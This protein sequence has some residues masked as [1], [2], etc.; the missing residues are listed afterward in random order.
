MH[1]E[2]RNLACDFFFE[3][4]KSICSYIASIPRSQSDEEKKNKVH[5]SIP[6]GDSS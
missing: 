1:F 5:E 3:E 2:F 6:F 4:K